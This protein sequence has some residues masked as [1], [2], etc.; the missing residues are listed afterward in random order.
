MIDGLYAMAGSLDR[1]L[2]VRL[3]KGA[4]WDTEI[5]HAQVEGLDGYPVFTQKPARMSVTSPCRA[6]CSA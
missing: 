1:R 6:S 4:Y 3:V 5:K 2:M